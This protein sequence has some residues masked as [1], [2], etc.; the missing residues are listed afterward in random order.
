MAIHKVKQLPKSS[1]PAVHIR[2]ERNTEV[3]A[4]VISLNLKSQDKLQSL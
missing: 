3:A 1:K 4:C 2:Y